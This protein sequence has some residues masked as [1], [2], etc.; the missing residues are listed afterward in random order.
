MYGERTT[1][2]AVVE[3]ASPLEL[4]RAWPSP[5]DIARLVTLFVRVPAGTE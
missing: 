3:D 4:D 1:E 2:L 5:S